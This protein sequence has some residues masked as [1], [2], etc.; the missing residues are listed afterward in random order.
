MYFLGLFL[1]QFWCIC[2]LFSNADF[3]KK[4]YTYTHTLTQLS[5]H[6]LSFKLILFIAVT[7]Q[8]FL[9]LL[10]KYTCTTCMKDNE[11]NITFTLHSYLFAILRINFVSYLFSWKWFFTI[12]SHQNL[13]HDAR[14][15]FHKTICVL[16]KMWNEYNCNI[17]NKFWS[18]CKIAKYKKGFRESKSKQTCPAFARICNINALDPE[19]KHSLYCM[20]LFLLAFIE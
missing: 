18:A 4:P 19:A 6:L 7:P 5:L 12:P 3:S 17:S 14:S 20:K 8:P 9:Y 15:A 10:K 11:I 2:W 16:L 1:T 13:A